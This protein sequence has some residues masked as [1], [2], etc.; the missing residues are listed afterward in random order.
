MFL[1]NCKLHARKEINQD[2]CNEGHYIDCT[3]QRL[4]AVGTTRDLANHLVHVRNSDYIR[5]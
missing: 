2:K 5:L 1:K 3:L 4:V